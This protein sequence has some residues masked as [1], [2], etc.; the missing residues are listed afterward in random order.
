MKRLLAIL[1]TFLC[2]LSM[3]AQIPLEGTEKNPTVISLGECYQLPTDFFTNAYFTFTAEADGVLY[4]T[5]SQPIKIFGKGGPLPIFGKD[6]VQGMRK[7]D[8]YTFY[9]TSTWGDSITMI[10]SFV[11]GKPYLP[12]DIVSTSIANGSTYHTT[13]QDGDI[14]FSFNVAINATKVRATL[15]LNS[16]KNV[17]LNSYRTS[18]DYNTLGTNYVLQLAATY[19]LLLE[20]GSLKPGDTFTITLNDIVSQNDATNSYDRELTLQL[21]ASEKVARLESISHH[22]KLMSY[23][24]P[25]DEKG[26]ITLTFSKE[27]TCNEPHATLSYGDR[28]T[29]T[30]T[31]IPVPYTI[32]GNTITWNVQEI[33]LTNVPTDNE[34]NRYVNISLKNIC[35]KDGFP[36]ESNAE[37]TTGT[38]LFSYL[39]ETMDINI[40]PDF[41]PAAG[42]NID[43]TNEVEI[44]ISA[45]KYITFDGAKVT[46]VKEGAS[47][48]EILSL[49]QLRQEDDPYSESDLL[50][51]VPIENYSFEASEVTI[52]LTNV[53]A[54][55]GTNPEIKVIYKSEGTRVN[56]IDLPIESNS[57]V[58]GIWTIDGRPISP[59]RQPQQRGFY[60]QKTNDGK[61]RKVIHE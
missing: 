31:E 57:N 48:I 1:T 5:L 6:C 26:F 51:Y 42:S 56:H 13:L 36:I 32:S 61:V 53:S 38:I 17:E 40:Y 28:E 39:V 23:Y 2:T 52:E 46:Y 29:G 7:G 4:L 22:D 44:W 12:V 41:M 30:W 8:T 60:L 15:T 24:M 19:N 34:G 25:G 37:G 58:T 3:S 27:V 59:N 55:N 14:T 54:A 50:V 20:E 45:G 21:T 18:E 47:T 9:N 10:P 33:H 49:A 11:E 43:Q 16:G 35:D